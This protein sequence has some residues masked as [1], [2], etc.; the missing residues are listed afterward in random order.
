MDHITLFNREI[1]LYGILFYAGM[2]LAALVALGVARRRGLPAAEVVYSAVYTFVGA[3]LGA[4]LLFI[5]VN[6][7]TIIESG[8]PFVAVVK[9][10]FVF[11][12]GFLGGLIGLFLYTRQFKL[13]I[14]GYLDVYAVVL[15]LG[16]AVGRIGCFFAGCCYGIPWEG[17]HVYTNVVGDTPLGIPLL[18]IQLIES[19]CLMLLFLAQLFFLCRYPRSSGL[20]TH[21]YLLS[22]PVV[23]F[24]LEFFRG[25]AQRGVLFLSTSQ[26]ISLAI[27]VF[28]LVTL[29][30]RARLRLNAERGDTV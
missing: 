4:K 19:A 22:Y 21:F 27:L 23:R 13:P 1:P 17:G 9:G 11:Y 15:P 14:G 29:T 2:L 3:L 24:V 25:D 18:P 28:E 12:G 7:R 6:L 20:H 26:W 5:A 30:R 8:I 10:G 16:H